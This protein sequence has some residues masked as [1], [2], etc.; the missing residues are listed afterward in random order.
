MNCGDYF[1]IKDYAFE[2]H[3]FYDLWYPYLCKDI[4]VKLNH[5]LDTCLIS[6]QRNLLR[7]AVLCLPDSIFECGHPHTP[8]GTIPKK[9]EL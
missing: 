3:K 6:S 4:W 1:Q 2:G 8:N 9:N 5:S 7:K